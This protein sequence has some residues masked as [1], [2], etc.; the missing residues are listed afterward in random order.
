MW[1]YA[2]SGD[3]TIYGVDINPWA[4]THES[5]NV[6]ILI[7]DQS[8]RTFWRTSGLPMLDFIL[9]DGGHTY[10]QQIVTFEA[11]W[12]FL[13]PGGVYMCEDT[14]TSYWK[15]P[16]SGGLRA[17]HTFME[18]MKRRVDYLNAAYFAR[19]DDAAIAE[20][21]DAVFFRSQVKQMAF[22][23]SV[24]VLEKH[25]KQNYWPPTVS[26]RGALNGSAVPA[27]G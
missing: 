8:N 16:Y 23:D 9:D 18:Y 4:K 19:D 10:E 25:G 14:H 7:G 12:E 2:F 1:D 15:Q 27:V 24:V 6:H 21:E 3:V 13:K 26:K 22:Y 11:L 20:H 5:T 17:P